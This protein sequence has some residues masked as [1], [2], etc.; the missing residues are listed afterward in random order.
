MD[1]TAVITLRSILMEE[2]RVCLPGL[3]TLVVDEQPATVSLLEGAAHPPT[4]RLSFNTNLITD[5]GR[6][7]ER[8]PHPADAAAFLRHLSE[9]LD[10]GQPVILEGIGKLYR[11]TTGQLRFQSAGDNF[12]RANYGLPAL[13]VTPLVRTEPHLQPP[14]AKA[15]SGR[16]NLPKR[17]REKDRARSWFWYAGGV[18]AALILLF[19]VFRIGGAIAGF[20][21]SDPVAALPVRSTPNL[22]PIAR[23]DP[24]IAAASVRPDPAPSLSEVPPSAASAERHTAIIAI[25]LYGRQRNVNKQLRRLREAGY[26]PHTATEGRNTRVGVE[27]NYRSE[28][29]LLD[30]LQA[31][32]ARY[33]EDAFIMLV[34]GEEQRYQ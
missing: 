25:G 26:T 24:P 27:V 28:D 3:G 17:Q 31:I 13:A 2:G 6:L 7:R 34:D 32:R 1:Q 33:T 12:S 22:P 8:L 9:Q 11:H 10:R 20:F 19:L 21:D 5:D 14:P 16:R 23:P 29:A 30:T 4:A 18:V 15:T